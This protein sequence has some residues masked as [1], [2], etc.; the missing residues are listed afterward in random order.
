M[1]SLERWLVERSRKWGECV[2]PKDS[3][4]GVVCGEE[5]ELVVVRDVGF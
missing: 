4:V 3:D 5:E 2:M 1:T